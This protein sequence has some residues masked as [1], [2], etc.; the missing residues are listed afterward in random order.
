MTR[1]PWR[2]AAAACAF[3]LLAIP[4][5]ANADWEYTRWG[6]TVDEVLAAARGKAQ[7][8]KA[9]KDTDIW[10]QS[11]LAAG[12][13]VQNGVTY[14]AGFYF[15]RKTRLLTMVD[16]TPDANDCDDAY[17]NFVS[18][19]GRGAVSS[20]S[21][22]DGPG[23]LKLSGEVTKWRKDS[24]DETVRFSDLTMATSDFRFCN[25]IFMARDFAAPEGKG[26]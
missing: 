26:E 16:L 17:D 1:S 19:L 4:A 22:N 6:M 7:P 15:D 5:A 20:S 10:G 24:S 11:Q 13:F 21:A 9:E 2:A 8:T 25:A 12:V 23:K 18:R 14:K 3:G